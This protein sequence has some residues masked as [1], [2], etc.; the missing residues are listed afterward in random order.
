MA[1]HIEA[2]IAEATT[3]RQREPTE[4]EITFAEH[5]REELMDKV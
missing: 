5:I 4:G 1:Y 3:R 2:F